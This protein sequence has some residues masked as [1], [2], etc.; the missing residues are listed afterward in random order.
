M[1]WKRGKR[2]AAL[3]HKRPEQLV[4]S[5][6]REFGV[7]RGTRARGQVWIGATRRLGYL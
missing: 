2:R 6:I 4:E 3:K 1:K 7:V 5:L